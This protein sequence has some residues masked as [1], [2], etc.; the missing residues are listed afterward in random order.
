MSYL[1]GMFELVR[2]LIYFTCLTHDWLK[3]SVLSMDIPGVLWLVRPY[4]LDDAIDLK[5]LEYA[6]H[7]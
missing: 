1:Q 5:G 6:G 4:L 7:Q 3:N 2:G